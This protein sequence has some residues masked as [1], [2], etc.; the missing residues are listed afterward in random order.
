MFS[1]SWLRTVGNVQ[2]LLCKFRSASNQLTK[3]FFYQ[4]S[5]VWVKHVH[6]EGSRGAVPLIRLV[7]LTSHSHNPSSKP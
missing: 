3:Y 7:F 6:F 4:C 5:N 2:V 1:F